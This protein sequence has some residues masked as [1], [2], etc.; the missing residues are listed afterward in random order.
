MPEHPILSD[1]ARREIRMMGL[2]PEVTVS[3]CSRCGKSSGELEK[4]PHPL[5]AK[6]TQA[7][8]LL[9]RDRKN[10]VLSKQVRDLVDKMHYSSRC[11]QA[12]MKKVMADNYQ[13][14]WETWL[15][16]EIRVPDISVIRRA[17]DAAQAVSAAQQQQFQQRVQTVKP[18][19]RIVAGGPAMAPIG[20]REDKRPMDPDFRRMA[21]LWGLDGVL[22]KA[23]IKIF[24]AE[25]ARQRNATV[26]E[27]VG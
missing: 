26:L 9:E 3:I 8:R 7:R 6:I 17:T 15:D 10:L 18:R 16:R 24:R 2:T 19:T 23:L 25:E 13:P 21:F 20:V 4:G 1:Q 11:C 5:L 27:A 22:T 14:L 12:R